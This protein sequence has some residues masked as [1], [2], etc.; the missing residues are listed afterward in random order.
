MR[1]NAASETV[2]P[3]PCSEAR[4]L[5]CSVDVNRSTRHV[6]R[7]DYALEPWNL[8]AVSNH[9]LH[10][11]PISHPFRTA[12]LASDVYSLAWRLIGWQNVFLQWRRPTPGARHAP[13]AQ[14]EP[15]SVKTD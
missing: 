9:Q 11:T 12:R 6:D 13:L 5:A 10:P 4:R 8:C 1:S 14:S 3:L 2:S 7:Y 15:P